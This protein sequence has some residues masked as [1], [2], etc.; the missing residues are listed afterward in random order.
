MLRLARLLRNIGLQE[1]SEKEKERAGKFSI[2]EDQRKLAFEKIKGLADPN[3]D[4][5]EAV[6]R[7]HFFID[8]DAPFTLGTMRIH[9]I[10]LL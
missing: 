9:Q 8:P 10:W 1:E 6:R 4:L 7:S 2:S 5:N 3:D